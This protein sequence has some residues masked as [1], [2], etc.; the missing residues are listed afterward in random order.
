MAFYSAER[1]GEVRE[2]FKILDI[3]LKISTGSQ[4]QNIMFS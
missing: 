4:P 2:S 3:E 1:R